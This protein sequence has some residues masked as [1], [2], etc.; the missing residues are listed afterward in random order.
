MKK[1]IIGIIVVILIAVSGWYFTLDMN[2]S[3]LTDDTGTT[4]ELTNDPYSGGSQLGK[5]V[6]VNGQP[7]GGLVS[8]EKG[9]DGK[10]Y[11]VNALGNKYILVG[12]VWQAL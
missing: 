12:E 10:I 7:N 6:L 9:A 11:G 1:I 8:I 2:S 4:V 3:K 5:Q